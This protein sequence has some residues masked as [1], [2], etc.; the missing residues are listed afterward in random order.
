VPLDFSYTFLAVHDTVQELLDSGKAPIYI[1]HFSQREASERAQALTSLS[2]LITRRKN[3]ALRKKLV[4]SASP[5]HLAK[6]YQNW[7]A[8]ALVFTMPACCQST[9][10]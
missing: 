8:A 6:T 3:N 1:V 10:A 4:L 5:R 7:S 2:G 9:G